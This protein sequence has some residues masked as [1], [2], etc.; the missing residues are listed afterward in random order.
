MK[1]KTTLSAGFQLR[2]WQK[3][4]VTLMG[5]LLMGAMWRLRG[6]DGF[7]S[8]WGMLP[9][10]FAFFLF[11]FSIF[12]YRKKFGYD[13][14]PWIVVS[15]PFTINGWMP[16]MPLLKGVIE[17]PTGMAENLVTNE[18]FSYLSAVLL[19]FLLGFG[20]MT[21]MGFFLGCLF[22]PKRFKMRNIVLTLVVFL[23]LKYSFKILFSHLALHLVAPQAIDVFSRG[24]GVEGITQSP[25]KF[26]LSNYFNSNIQKQFIGGRVYYNCVSVLSNAAGAVGVI[27]LLFFKFKDKIAA[28]IMLSVTSLVGCAFLGGALVN[29]LVCD[30]F[31][32]TFDSSALPSWIMQNHWGFVEYSVGFFIGLGVTAFLVFQKQELLNAHRDVTED[33]PKSARNK[34]L[35][36]AYHMFFTAGFLCIASIARPIAS[37]I[38]H[39][40]DGVY[41]S[42]IVILYLAIPAVLLFGVILWKNIIKKQLG[43]PFAFPF[44]RFTLVAGPFV[45]LAFCFT[46]M[47]I[48]TSFWRNNSTWPLASQI[49]LSSWA[50]LLGYIVL[51]NTNGINGR[52]TG[53]EL[54]ERTG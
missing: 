4:L 42:D 43:Q 20:W 27:A 5:A 18:N 22:S 11:L 47:F 30:G 31:R 3:L 48:G 12:G 6:D 17:A 29:V 36:F 33:L 21:F 19:V 44:H 25:F 49:F 45:F 38:D 41:K 2:T 15:V 8:F 37:R 50:V 14:L 16:V 32:N 53:S 46:D 13:A 28:R 7:G 9:V 26:F 23:L 52:L 34:W 24:L 51:Y 1:H 35:C 40:S 39:A 54:K 10:S